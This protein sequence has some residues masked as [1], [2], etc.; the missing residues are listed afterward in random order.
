MTIDDVAVPPRA[1]QVLAFWFGEP[2]SAAY[3]RERPE[4]FRKDPAFDEAIR[5]HFGDLVQQAR[6]QQLQEWARQPASA[7]ALL[8]VCDQF[9]RNLFRGQA[10]AFE[11]DARAL[12]LARDVVA[13]GWDV[14]LLPLQRWFAY[15]P[16]EHAESID[17]QREALR[18]FGLLRHD[19]QVGGAYEWAVK[20]FEVIERF[21]R[22]PHRNA[23]LGRTSTAAEIDFLN[24]PGSSF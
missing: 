13:H 2:A 21:G 19:P 24:Q 14:T 20:H 6:A 16:F 5:T 11:L 8:L 23:A 7:L 10:D 9:P 17:D 4:W 18:L 15:L 3:G 1:A 22:F 12:G